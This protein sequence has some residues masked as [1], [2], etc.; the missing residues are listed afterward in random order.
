MKTSARNR[1]VGQIKSLKEG[2]VNT[3][4]VIDLGGGDELAAVITHDSAADLRLAPGV[5]VEAIF[6]ASWVMVALPDSTKTSARNHLCGKVARIVQGPV[7]SEIVIALSGGQSVAA[8]ITRDSLEQLG[9]KEGDPA[10]ALIK[11]TQI[12]L[13][14]A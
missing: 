2:P 3:E 9:L 12:I 11:A 10:C 14:V 13:A 8:T 1:F 6:K 7:N 5:E 4:V